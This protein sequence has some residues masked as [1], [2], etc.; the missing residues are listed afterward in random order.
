M[1]QDT[2]PQAID[3]GGAAYS[4]M[5]LTDVHTADA[6]CMSW[7]VPRSST[8]PASKEQARQ[9]TCRKSELKCFNQRKA[10]IIRSV[11]FN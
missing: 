10:V 11:L 5:K 9:E 6:R 1:L 7:F 8:L 4:L 2:S 3:I